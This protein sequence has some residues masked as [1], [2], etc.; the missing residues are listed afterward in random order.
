MMS[1]NIYDGVMMIREGI[2]LPDS[3]QTD[4]VSYSGAW[5]SMLGLDS[6]TAGRKLRSAGLHLFFMAGQLKVIELGWGAGATRR[7]LKR[8]LAQG[9]K[10]N[11]NCMEIDQVRPARFL[12]FPYVAISA[13]SF[14]IQKG[15]GLDTDAERNSQQK[16][17]DWAHG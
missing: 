16:D 17:R 7:G 8:I 2:L 4:T 6:F 13:H 15:A 10:R 9:R 1:P 3:M 5:R 12:G 14:H 11:L